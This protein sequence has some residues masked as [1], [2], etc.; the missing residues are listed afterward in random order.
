MYSWEVFLCDRAGLPC[1]LVHS[2]THQWNK[3][4]VEGKWWDV[5][6]TSN[7][8]GDD[9]LHR[10]YSTVL[11]GSAEMQGKDYINEAPEITAF[12]MEILVPGST[13]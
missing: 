11:C 13:K 1:L 4:Y 3:V 5:D 12:A 2:K 7:D 10:A 9:T 8:V 6:V